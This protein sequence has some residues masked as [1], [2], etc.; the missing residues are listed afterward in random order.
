M[1]SQITL[2]SQYQSLAT[3]IKRSSETKERIMQLEAEN[4]A[5]KQE[6]SA[7]RARMQKLVHE[8]LTI[9]RMK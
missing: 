7:M 1:I 3:Q 4:R 6:L 9:R 8:I 2:I 5:L